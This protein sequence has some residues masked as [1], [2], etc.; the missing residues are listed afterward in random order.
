MPIRPENRHYYGRIWRAYRAALIARHGA[1]C[2]SCG[3]EVPKYLNLCHLERDPE[4]SGVVELRCPSCHGR[5]DARVNFAL[6]RRTRARK[7]GQRWLL[8]ELEYAPTP[9][10][11]I[12]GRVLAMIRRALQGRLFTQ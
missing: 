12:P 2:R 8:P 6:G 5:Y 11:A 10:S 9:L 1:F 3:R 4:R 7:T